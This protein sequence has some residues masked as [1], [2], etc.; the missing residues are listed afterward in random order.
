MWVASTLV[1]DAM[2][3]PVSAGVLLPPPERAILEAV[4]VV[5][6]TAAVTTPQ[7]QQI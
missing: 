2:L 4:F 5:V 6:A 3:V 1:T 7:H